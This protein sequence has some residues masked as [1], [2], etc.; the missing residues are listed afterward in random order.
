MEQGTAVRRVKRTLTK[1]L[2]VLLMT[3]MCTD[4]K[5]QNKAHGSA[6]LSLTIT[7]YKKKNLIGTSSVI[8]K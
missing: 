3:E 6:I 1:E 8:C 5:S 2:T 4:L 7:N